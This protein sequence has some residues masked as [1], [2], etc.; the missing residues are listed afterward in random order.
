VLILAPIIE[1]GF[2]RL[3]AEK[4]IG[5]EYP[6]KSQMFQHFFRDPPVTFDRVIGLGKSDLTPHSE[7]YTSK[8]ESRLK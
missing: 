6:E 7:R 1:H 2:R 3:P 5:K 8:K 4:K